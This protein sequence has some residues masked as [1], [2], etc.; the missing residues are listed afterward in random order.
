M[1]PHT[2][3][4]C[5][6]RRTEVVWKDTDIHVDEIEVV[7]V[8]AECDTQ[9]SVMYAVYDKIVNEAQPIEEGGRG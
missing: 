3:P 5:D 2:C 9:Y 7:R 1:V 6:N 8:C 4:E